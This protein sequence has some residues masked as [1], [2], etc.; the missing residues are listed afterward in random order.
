MSNIMRMLS[1]IKSKPKPEPKP[2]Q[3]PPRLPD[4][5]HFRLQYDADSDSWTEFWQCPAP[6]LTATSIAGSERS[7][8]S[9]AQCSRSSPSSIAGIGRR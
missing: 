2:R 3:V 9:P 6:I 8:P 1:A 7:E 5:A 4:K